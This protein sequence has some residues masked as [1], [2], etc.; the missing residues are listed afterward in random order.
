MKVQLVKLMD[1]YYTIRPADPSNTTI[2]MIGVASW[3]SVRATCKK[4][5][6]KVVGTVDRTKKVGV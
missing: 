6:W 2:L 4:N 1:N 5:G 3:A